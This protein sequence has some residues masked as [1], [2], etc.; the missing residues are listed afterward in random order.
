MLRA[1]AVSRS[2]AGVRALQEVTL[3]LESRHEVV[4]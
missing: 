4:G 3:E 1:A 2:F